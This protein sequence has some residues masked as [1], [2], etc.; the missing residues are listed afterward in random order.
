ML[1]IKSLDLPTI[2][3]GKTLVTFDPHERYFRD[4][5]G[6]TTGGTQLHFECNA[7]K[8]TANADQFAP[9]R[10]FHHLGLDFISEFKG[11]LFR[12]PIRTKPSELSSNCPPVDE[13]INEILDSFLKDLHLLLLFLRNLERIEVYEITNNARECRLLA[14]T[15][16]DFDESSRDLREKRVAYREAL[17]RTVLSGE[18]TMS[19]KAFEL[20]DV[21]INFRMSIRAKIEFKDQPFKESVDRY[22][23]CNYVRLKSATKVCRFLAKYNFF[24]ISIKIFY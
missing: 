5:K 13:L 7:D 18:R 19:E 17:D 11:T 23:I 20:D 12:F 16:I 1:Y 24:L 21:E 22:L 9:F 2:I 4:S 6:N 8:F 14:S 10:T 3:S 15:W